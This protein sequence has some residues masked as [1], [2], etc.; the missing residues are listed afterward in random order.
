M[1]TA[2]LIPGL[3]L[4]GALLAPAVAGAQASYIDRALATAQEQRIGDG[5]T[6]TLQPYR[7]RAADGQR[8]TVRWTLDG[9]RTYLIHAVCDESCSDVDIVVR[10]RNG[11]VVARDEDEDDVPLVQFSAETGGEYTVDFPM[12][13]CRTAACAVGARL[14]VRHRQPTDAAR[15]S[16]DRQMDAVTRSM[17][18][19]QYTAGS[20]AITYGVADGDGVEPASFVA[21]AGRAYAVVGVCDLDCDDLDMVIKAPDGSI[22]GR[23]LATDD[24][25]VVEFV[26]QE[27][28]VYTVAVSMASCKTSKCVFGVSSFGRGGASSTPTLAGSPAGSAGACSVGSARESFAVGGRVTGR[29]RTESSR[30][31][32]GSHAEYYRLVLTSRTAVT[33]V[34]RSAEFDAY[35]DVQDANGRSVANDDDGD[36][37]TDARVATTLAAGTYSVIANSLTSGKTGS[38]SLAVSRQ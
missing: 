7:G 22:V 24:T 29:L 1:T 2:H 23:D 4:A 27:S 35:L 37:G 20:P 12:A 6:S 18:S 15:G 11:R 28:G 5:F 32:D 16:I 14:F 13:D 30:R 25:P 17:A 9:G 31:G 34:L 8:A 38:F 33:I 26:A 36:G 10:D 21:T 19:R 3:A